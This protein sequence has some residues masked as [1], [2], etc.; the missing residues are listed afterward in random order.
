MIFGECSPGAAGLRN[1]S[2]VVGA[3]TSRRSTPPQT[4]SCAPGL[5]ALAIETPPCVTDRDQCRVDRR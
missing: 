2:S 1:D 3:I 5:R 4:P